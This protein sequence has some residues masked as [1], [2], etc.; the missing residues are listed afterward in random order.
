M[1]RPAPRDPP[2]GPLPRRREPVTGGNPIE[3]I[4]RS[5]FGN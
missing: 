4:L 2:S 3:N 5:L 1:Q